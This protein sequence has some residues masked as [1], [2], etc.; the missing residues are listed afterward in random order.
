MVQLDKLYISN[1]R[2]M[3]N[4]VN[5]E[6]GK[7][8]TI[9]LAPNGT[10]KTTIFE[11][12]ELAL[13]G[14]IQRLRGNNGA[15][16]GDKSKNMSVELFFNNDQVTKLCL[17]QEG[18]CSRDGDIRRIL[19]VQDEVS[20]PYLFKM[21]HFFE[22]N[23]KN[24][25][26]GCD[27]SEAG[28]LLSSLPISKDIQN[29]LSKRMSVLRAVTGLEVNC[30]TEL[31]LLHSEFDQFKELYFKLKELKNNMPHLDKCKML[32]EIFELFENYKILTEDG[33]ELDSIAGKWELIKNK[34]LEVKDRNM[35]EY[36][37]L[38]AFDKRISFYIEN[39][40]KI[41]EANS[42]I[43]FCAEDKINKEYTEADINNIRTDILSNISIIEKE[44]NSAESEIS[45]FNERDI[46]QRGIV[47]KQNDIKKYEAL[48]Q[49]CQ[50]NIE[51]K[52]VVIETYCNLER[53]HKNITESLG[54]AKKRLIVLENNRKD[55][56]NLETNLRDLQNMITNIHRIDN[57]LAI[58]QKDKGSI[59]KQLI[60]EKDKQ[61]NKHKE[62]NLLRNSGKE[63]ENALSLLSHNIDLNTKICP[64]C[65]AEYLPGELQIRISAA[66]G[67][68]NP[69]VDKTIAE[70]K[71]IENVI[72][73]LEGIL[74]Q[75]TKEIVELNQNHV[76]ISLKIS[77][78]QTSNDNIK[79]S[80]LVDENN[81]IE[82]K[83]RL[84]QA[85]IQQKCI[86]LEL[87]NKNDSL[88][89]LEENKYNIAREYKDNQERKIKESILF[90]DSLKLDIANENNAIEILKKKLEGK[91]INQ[92]LEKISKCLSEIKELSDK[93]KGCNSRHNALREEIDKLDEMLLSEKN[94]V[95]VLK[96]T[97]D[98]ILEEWK[99]FNI[100]SSPDM[101]KKEAKCNYLKK[102]DIG[103]END[104]K[105]FYDLQNALL[106]WKNYETGEDIKKKIQ[107]MVGD[108]NPDTFYEKL[109]K[110][111]VKK[112]TEID[113][114]KIKKE[115]VNAFLDKISEES[116]QIQVQFG[117]INETWKRIL[118]R[119]VVN[120]LITSAPLL[121]NRTSRNKQIATTLAEINGEKFD[122]SNI[123]SEG[124]IADLQLSFILAMANKYSWTPWKALL[125]D[126]PMQHHDLVHAASAFDVLRDY[127]VELDYQIMLST[128]D[129]LQADFF[130]RKL[131]NDGILSKVY[132]LVPG[133]GGVTAERIN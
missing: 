86:V 21:T 129:P 11:A 26:V 71:N 100:G 36:N 102:L 33:E 109:K 122:I 48:I 3:G 6:F 28:K 40:I 59:E 37:K 27:G 68:L 72:S 125:L 30:K 119:I 2:R 132:Q 51:N 73:S 31:R 84:D 52:Q 41:S 133:K 94:K 90:I 63:I 9:L 49:E 24:W 76:E 75:I 114:I 22:Q 116:E 92:Y 43:N 87:Q 54:N 25:F 10:G 98:S 12:I 85:L 47:E 58:K 60:D 127:I 79:L 14:E 124:Q 103:L 23:S 53:Q 111:I 105:K 104:L 44:K 19:N 50:K 128:H 13:T 42:R 77:D 101:E 35:M 121:N 61:E 55:I 7:G 120:P 45:Q 83:F 64:V 56:D 118:K 107:D 8:V 89:L 88:P 65:Q 29:I 34:I 57:E 123:A 95:S 20:I 106:E 82:E 91:D 32:T 17:D 1:A 5:I 110:S 46:K 4:D 67:S 69:L 108:D 93:L 66:L 39:Q 99:H 62:I 16:I 74:N 113:N 126:D 81:I 38:S 97:Q 115:T 78:L 80:I 15:I 130:V 96:V 70:E 112:E 117:Q 131:K 18:I